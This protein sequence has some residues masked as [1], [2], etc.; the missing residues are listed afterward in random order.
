MYGGG[1][2][3]LISGILWKGLLFHFFKTGTILDSLG[4]VCEIS[5]VGGE[6]NLVVTNSIWKNE[7]EQR[8]RVQHT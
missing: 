2:D 4:G 6:I 8:I 3:Y 5:L 1:Q 7:I